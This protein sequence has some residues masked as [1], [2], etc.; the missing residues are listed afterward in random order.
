[1]TDHTAQFARVLEASERDMLAG[2]RRRVGTD[3]RTS[4]EI[5]ANMERLAAS[6]E[7]AAERERFYTEVAARDAAERAKQEARWAAEDREAGE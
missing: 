1:M 4:G 2:F 3:A 6:P 5:V 7:A